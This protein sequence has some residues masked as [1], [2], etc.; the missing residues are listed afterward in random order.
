ME[1]GHIASEIMPSAGARAFRVNGSDA[2]RSFSTQ[3]LFPDIRPKLRS[4]IA[5]ETKSECH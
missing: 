2:R 1:Y 3:H 5:D 4:Q